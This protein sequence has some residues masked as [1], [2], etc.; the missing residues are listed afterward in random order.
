MTASMARDAASKNGVNLQ[1]VRPAML[2][3][4]R[5]AR[6]QALERGGAGNVRL[7]GA[8]ISPDGAQPQLGLGR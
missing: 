4:A 8:G 5:D 2:G 3:L 6:R 7:G 1:G